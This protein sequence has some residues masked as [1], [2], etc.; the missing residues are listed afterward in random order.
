V[1]PDDDPVKGLFGFRL[2]A[3]DLN[4]REIDVVV[5]R[6]AYPEVM[7]VELT[8]GNFFGQVF[9]DFGLGHCMFRCHHPE[10]RKARVI[11]LTCKRVFTSTLHDIGRAGQM[12]Q[13]RELDT[14]IIRTPGDK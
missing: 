6:R 3:V 8:P 11:C 14:M 10:T 4:G 5:Q 13:L 1:L 9:E 2:E 12:E 7:E